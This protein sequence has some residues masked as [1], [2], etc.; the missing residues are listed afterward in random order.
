MRLDGELLDGPS[1]TGAR[2]L[3]LGRLAD[4]EEAGARLGDP[5]DAEALHDFRVAVRRLRS[6][7]RLLAPALKGVLGEKPARRLA[8]V[9]RRTGPARDAE[10]LSAW[11]QEA[12][13]QLGAPYRGALDWLLDRVERRR[14]EGAREV[15]EEALPR[16][17]RLAPRLTRRLSARPRPASDIPPTLAALLAGVIRAQ[18]RALREALAAVVGGEDAVGLHR[19]RI[20]G[21]RLRYLLEPLR[22]LAGADASEA[23]AALKGLQE[24][25]GTWHDRHQAREALAG[26]LVEA[27]ADRARRGRD[28]GSGDLRPGLMAIDQRAAREAD[29]VYGQLAEAF[30]R[31]RATGVLDL[32]YAVVAGL[33]GPAAEDQPPE[34]APERRLLLTGLPGQA[35][36]GAV[37]EVAQGW[38]PG[39]RDHVGTVRSAGGERWF[40]A[41]PGPRGST[42]VESITRADFEAWWPLTE[43]RRLSHRSLRSADLPG[44]RF[45]EFTDRRLV[46]AV[47]EAGG[48]ATPPDWL[49]PVV[50]RDVTG[51]RGYRDEALARRGSRRG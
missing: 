24:L 6:T 25:L 4:A 13:G 26:A 51:E 11:L 16:F 14:A 7:L 20:E 1:T 5:A 2:V 38:L 47:F 18:A 35:A 50:V 27:A 23:V 31:T 48:E 32:A 21:K 46:L 10:V 12:R 44:W 39:E 3:A 17:R 28:A 22:G 15:L 9:T 19:A 40:R 49:E 43:G 45:D 36:G 42:E 8:R 30:L 34:V 33:E 29:E 41:R 37:E